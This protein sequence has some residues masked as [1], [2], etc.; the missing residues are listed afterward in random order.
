MLEKIEYD[1]TLVNE[2][3]IAKAKSGDKHAKEL[4]FKNNVP[5]IRKLVKKWINRGATTNYDELISIGLMAMLKAYEKFDSN[6]GIKFSTLAGKY[7]WNAFV[8]NA[9]YAERQKFTLFDTCSMDSEFKK[10]YNN[11]FTFHDV[12][13]DEKSM[14]DYD[15]VNKTIYFEEIK[16]KFYKIADERERIVFDKHFGQGISLAEIAREWNVSRQTTSNIHKKL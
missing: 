5:F 16:N 2:V 15:A 12:I 9:I 1:K 6:K 11:S 13:S 3:L 7:I 14:D 8:R 4:L 10:D